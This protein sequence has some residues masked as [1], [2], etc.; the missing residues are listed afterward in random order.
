[1]PNRASP[2][3]RRRLGRA[4]RERVVREFDWERKIDQMLDI[5]TDTVCR[6]AGKARGQLSR[7]E[8]RLRPVSR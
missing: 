7:R 8:R 5:Y 6:A 4:G 3:Q 1:M 2:S